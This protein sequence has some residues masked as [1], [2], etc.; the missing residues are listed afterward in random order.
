MTPR[1]R[2]L[3]ASFSSIVLATSGLA[4]VVFAAAP[5]GAAA[6]A[7]RPAASTAPPTT[8]PPTPTPSPTS[9]PTSPTPTPSPTAS[10]Q[11]GIEGTVSSGGS[12]LVGISVDVC[13]NYT[14]SCWSATT[15][16]TGFYEVTGLSPATY[17]VNADD[18]PLLPGH[19]GPIVLPAGV[20]E[21]ANL[22]LLANIPLPPGVTVPGA[23]GNP[24]LVHWD[25]FTPF[26]VAGQ[27]PGGTASFTI[28]QNGAVFSAGPLL[29][30]PL[31]SG[32]YKGVIP[33]FAPNHHGYGQITVT[34]VCPGGV[35][36]TIIFCIYIDPSGTVVDLDG[37][38][39]GGATVTLLT[40]AT[41]AGPFTPVPNGSAIMSPANRTNPVVTKA[42]GLFGWDVEPGYYEVEAQKTGCEAPSSPTSPVAVSQVLQIPPAVSGMLLTLD[43][44]DSPA[45]SITSAG[46]ATFTAGTAGSYTLS[47]TGSPDPTWTDSG[48]LPTGVT[49][50][51]EAEGT[52]DLVVSSAAAAGVTTFT[53][54]ANNGV[55]SAVSQ[56]FTVTI[57]PANGPVITSAPQAAF[58]EGTAGTFPITATGAITPIISESGALPAGVTLIPGN[59]GTAALN[60]SASAAAGST[61][62][63]L[64]ATSGAATTTQ[65]FTLTITA[66]APAITSAA[67][68]EF[69]LASGVSGTFTVTTSGVPTATVSETGALPPDVTFTPNPGGTATLAVAPSALPGT[70][71]FTITAVNGVSPAASQ[72][73]T[74]V[75][76]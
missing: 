11:T 58:T 15:N 3:I 60:V 43:C 61:T 14:S 22:V 17:V 35:V 4:A 54:I 25:T 68:A 20:V 42:D 30:T 73:F 76:S 51:P 45:T 44:A 28:V 38:P 71:T 5:A 57:N 69:T 63:T 2:R 39:V 52:A 33:P 8:H 10:G 7:V 12:P 21:I 34:I 70:T 49:F 50:E 55:G 9:L 66:P 23:S 47:A 18:S 1:R 6:G 62:L 13:I 48:T 37:L 75:V 72:T 41:A 29:E 40:A 27:C 74:L 59:N 24:P 56:T 65:N 64:T 16:S 53:A 26:F 32:T 36:V 67:T 19:N 31:G 46:A